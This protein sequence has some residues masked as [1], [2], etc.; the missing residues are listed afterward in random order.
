NGGRQMGVPYINGEMLRLLLFSSLFNLVCSYAIKSDWTGYDSGTFEHYFDELSALD[1]PDKGHGHHHGHHFPWY[2]PFLRNVSRSARRDFFRIVF[3]RNATKGEIKKRV[4]EWA[5]KNHVENEVKRWH[6]KVVA[7]F[8]EH[9]KNVTAAIG[10]LQGAY[11]SLTSIIK[12][13]S[14]THH[15]TY[16]KIHDLFVSYPRELRSILFA[17]RPLPPRRR[18]HDIGEEDYSDEIPD[19]IN[20]FGSIPSGLKFKGVGPVRLDTNRVVN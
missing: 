14:L 9:D 2:P 3:D 5:V 8:T 4:G 13:D 20:S 6:E 11:E 16:V 15:Q 18:P 17:T 7:Y 1:L 10:K 12:D 19:S